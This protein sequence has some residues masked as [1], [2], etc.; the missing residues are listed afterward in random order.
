MKCPCCDSEI[1]TSGFCSC[2]GINYTFIE[3]KPYCCPVCLGRGHVGN[4]FY[5]STGD[6]WTSSST[7]FETCKSCDGSGVVWG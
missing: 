7:E 1:T 5:K 6:S 3:K 4:S 2:K